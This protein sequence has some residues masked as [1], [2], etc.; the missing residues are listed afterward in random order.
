MKICSENAN[1]IFKKRAKST[2]DFSRWRLDENLPFCQKFCDL[3]L[4]EKKLKIFFEKTRQKYGR[5][6]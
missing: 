1:E 4:K 3:E 5:P 6:S 2:I